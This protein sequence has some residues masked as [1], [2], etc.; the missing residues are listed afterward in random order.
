MKRVT[1]HKDGKS[2]KIADYVESN[3]LYY[4]LEKNSILIPLICYIRLSW[5]NK[6]INYSST[7]FVPGMPLLEMQLTELF[8]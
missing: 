6:E 7:C 4:A 1:L 2:F 8:P 5:K 3:N